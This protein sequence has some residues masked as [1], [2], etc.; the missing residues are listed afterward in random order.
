MA[1][2]IHLRTYTTRVGGDGLTSYCSWKQRRYLC[3]I[4]V[5]SLRCQIKYMDVQ[6]T[7]VEDKKSFFSCNLM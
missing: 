5:L 4:H 7:L 3:K 1:N 2:E 6:D